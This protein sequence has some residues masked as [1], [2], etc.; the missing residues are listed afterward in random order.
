MGRVEKTICGQEGDHGAVEKV[1]LNGYRI[2][3]PRAAGAAYA[4]ICGFQSSTFILWGLPPCLSVLQHTP[5]P[6]ILI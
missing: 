5:E 2:S 1:R 4:V 3:I 6:V